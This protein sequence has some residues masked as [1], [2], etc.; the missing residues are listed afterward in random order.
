MSTRSLVLVS[1]LLSLGAGGCGSGALVLKQPVTDQCRGA[2]LEGCDALAEGVLKF[3]D[4]D[5]DAGRAKLAEGALANSGPKLAEFT[6]RLRQLK[7][8]PGASS[9]SDP[10]DEVLAILSRQA[11]SKADASPSSVPCAR[12]PEPP[13]EG[14]IAGAAPTGAAGFAFGISVDEARAVCIDGWE[15]AREVYRCAGLPVAVGIPA[16]ATLEFDRERLVSIGLEF[17]QPASDVGAG[18]RSLRAAL[19]RKYGAP[20]DQAVTGERMQLDWSF[21]RGEVRVVL[22][23]DL[24]ATAGRRMSLRYRRVASAAPLEAR[25]L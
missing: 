24:D 18:W 6:S 4:G 17:R 5:K 23:T 21:H 1:T 16:V 7:S 10:L 12:P 13:A 15:E 2:G 19:E 20:R 3:V 8:L 14:V 9:F 22:V 25:G 11:E